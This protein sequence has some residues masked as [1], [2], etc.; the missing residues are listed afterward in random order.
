MP[1][2]SGVKGATAIVTTHDKSTLV[3]VTLPDEATTGA[4]RAKKYDN[5]EQYKIRRVH[6]NVNVIAEIPDL[7]RT[8]MPYAHDC[9]P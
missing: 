5:T 6:L 3:F 7:L 8:V 9:T 4:Q 2:Q 1:T